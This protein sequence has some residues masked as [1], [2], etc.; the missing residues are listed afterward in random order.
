VRAVD[1]IGRKRDGEELSADEIEWL[2]R[3]SVTGE[4]ADYQISAWLM[5]VYLKGMSRSET[6]ALTRAMAHS[7]RVLDLG[8]LAPRAVDKHSSGGVGDKISLV[9]GPIAAAAGVVIP[10]MSGRGLGFTGGTLD[11][12]ESIPGLRVSLS[13]DQ[14][15]DQARRVGLVIASQTSDLAPADAK[16]YALRDVTATVGSLPLIVS[17]ILS[18]KLA[19]GAPAIV[20]DVKAG[21]GA[22]MPTAR[23]AE[24]LARALVDVGT[25][26]GRRVVALVSSMDQPLG[27]AV[28][29]AVEIREAV[30]TLRGRGPDD[31]R[32]LALAIASEMVQCAGLAD[33]DVPAR[34]RAR[35]ALVAGQA[36]AKLRAMVDAQGGDV[37]VIDDPS[38]L[39]RAPVVET[40]RS[41]FAGFIARLDAGIVGTT[42]TALGAGRERKGDPIDHRV[43]AIFYRKVGDRVEIGEPLFELHLARSDQRSFAQERLL[44]AYHWSREPV[45][46]PSIVIGRF[47]HHPAQ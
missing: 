6:I 46:R 21:S 1:V 12:L 47:S 17:S 45:P 14:I 20:L 34:D 30:E 36:L 27:H 43:G 4:V 5:A 7:G 38:R 37:G 44:E 26:C 42:L 33:G 35:E 40:V 41:P 32:D 8:D 18:K 9:A 11:K 22:F 24:G 39:P 2:V 10:K 23:Q 19:G 15:L 13:V 16:L 31:V 3:G 29:N 25:A 28:G